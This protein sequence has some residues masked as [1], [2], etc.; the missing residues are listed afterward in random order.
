M[1]ALKLSQPLTE[2]S[3][4]NI[5]WGEGGGAKATPVFRDDNLTTFICR[6]F[7]NFGASISWDSQS[8]SIRVQGVFTFTFMVNYSFQLHLLCRPSSSVGIATD[9]GL[10]DP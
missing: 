8:L 9:Y 5:S 7:G 10:D 3:T 2:M 1:L 4:R 6:L